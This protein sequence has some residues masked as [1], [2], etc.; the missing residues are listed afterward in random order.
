MD[1]HAERMPHPRDGADGVR[2]RPQ[3]RH[4]TQVLE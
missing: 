1:R 3:V 4:L 2:A